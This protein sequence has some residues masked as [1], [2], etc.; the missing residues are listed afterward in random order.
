MTKPDIIGRIR[1]LC[2]ER[3]ISLAQLERECGLG[4]KTISNWDKSA[5]SV[6][7]LAKIADYFG[8]KIDYLMGRDDPPDSYDDV[9]RELDAMRRDPNLRVLMSAS[10][11]LSEDDLRIVLALVKRMKGE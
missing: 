2:A 11:D 1:E 4:K 6:D 9:R 10:E 7:K 5:P 3:R 8:V